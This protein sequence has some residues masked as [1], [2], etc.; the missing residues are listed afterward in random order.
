[1]RIGLFGGSF[2]PPHV[3]HLIIA[4]RVREI[5]SLD[6]VLW[7][8]SAQPPHKDGSDLASALDRLEMVKLAIARNPAFLA[9]DVELQRDGPSYT[10]DTIRTLK[11]ENPDDK[12]FLII[13]GDSLVD[14]H[15]WREPESIVRELPLIVYDREGGEMPRMD[16]EPGRILRMTAPR[17]EISGTEIRSRRARGDSIRY[18]VRDSVKAYIES[19]QLYRE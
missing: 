10:I 3:A 14:F 16:F 7:M 13:G 11:R 19:R 5:Y 4:E 8:P 17:I 1:M 18:L 15:R 12:F 6:R 2:N 9:S